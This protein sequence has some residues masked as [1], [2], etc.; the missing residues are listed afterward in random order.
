M[1]RLLG[2]R[3]ASCSAKVAMAFQYKSFR[4]SFSTA[5]RVTSITRV[6][7]REVRTCGLTRFA[8]FQIRSFSIS[9][10]NN[11]N[12]N[13][14]NNNNSSSSSSSNC[15]SNSS[16]KPP[17][18]ELQRVGMDALTTRYR[19]ALSRQARGCIIS[20]QT[21]ACTRQAYMG[22]MVHRT[23]RRALRFARRLEWRLTMWMRPRIRCT[24]ACSQAR[25]GLRRIT[26]PP[27]TR[28]AHQTKN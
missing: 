27:S 8:L 6:I 13:C 5:A 9:S 28:C 10:S 3:T 26:L 25:S 22:S 24:V 16:D 11:S 20:T 15:N 12:S 4:F 14:R 2:V 21:P 17:S 7:F 23:Q 1:W 19:R 18:T